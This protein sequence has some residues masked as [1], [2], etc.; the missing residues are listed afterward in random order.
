MIEEII[1]SQI[2]LT[3][4]RIWRPVWTHCRL[5]CSLDSS[6]L[7]SPGEKRSAAVEI[8]PAFQDSLA[9]GIQA[10]QVDCIPKDRIQK[11]FAC[12]LQKTT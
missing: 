8:V 7:P 6:D 5:W 3:I 4:R 2:I 10:I 12:Q 9:L 1:R 11:L